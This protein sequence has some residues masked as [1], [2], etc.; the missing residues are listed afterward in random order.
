MSHGSLLQT[1]FY[2]IPLSYLLSLFDENI[3]ISN[4]CSP[5]F[6]FA[7]IV[8]FPAHFSPTLLYC[9]DQYKGIVAVYSALSLKM[10]SCIQHWINGVQLY[11]VQI[12]RTLGYVILQA[13]S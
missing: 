8:S 5:L 3:F 9:Y 2:L 6:P 7:S 4:S 10:W 13:D 11:E 12:N 1:T